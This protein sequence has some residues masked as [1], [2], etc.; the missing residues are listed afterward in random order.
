MGQCLRHVVVVKHC[1]SRKWYLCCRAAYFEGFVIYISSFKSFFKGFKSKGST[2]HTYMDFDLVFRGWAITKTGVTGWL[3]EKC[4]TPS[5]LVDFCV[6]NIGKVPLSILFRWIRETARALKPSFHSTSQ[7]Q[8][9]PFCRF[10]VENLA[11]VMKMSSNTILQPN[12]S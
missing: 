2:Q 11:K 8:I 12:A 9:F 4:Y 7:I 3:L 6:A 10:L 5:T 1:S